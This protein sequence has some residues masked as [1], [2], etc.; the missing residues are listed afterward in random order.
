MLGGRTAGEA[1]ERT[2]GAASSSPC[3]GLGGWTW[4]WG[5]VLGAW[6]GGTGHGGLD[7]R[8][9]APMSLQTPPG[10]LGTAVTQPLAPA[11][12]SRR[13]HTLSVCWPVPGPAGTSG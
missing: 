5:P 9:H 3:L 7:N 6:Q 13:P 2:W 1:E 12:W 11:P 4:S 10:W 8:H